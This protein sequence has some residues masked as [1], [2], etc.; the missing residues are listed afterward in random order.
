[1]LMNLKKKTKI[2]TK[3][4]KPVSK[5]ELSNLKT[6]YKSG[7]INF[8]SKKIAGNILKDFKPG[9]TK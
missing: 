9:L 4:E 6:A 3:T 1:M 8:D 5:K 2:K 7:K